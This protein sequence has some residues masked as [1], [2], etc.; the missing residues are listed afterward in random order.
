MT[1]EP[2]PYTIRPMELGDI[3]IGLLD[4]NIQSIDI[5]TRGEDP[6]SER[7]KHAEKRIKRTTGYKRAWQNRIQ[8]EG[9]KMEALIESIKSCW[10]S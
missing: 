8:D 4:R 7:A 1:Q 2:I 9:G 3:P 6:E 5:M 10:V